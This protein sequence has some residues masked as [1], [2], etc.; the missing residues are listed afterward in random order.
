LRNPQKNTI[1][2]FILA[3]STF[4]GA[5]SRGIAHVYPK[6]PLSSQSLEYAASQIL[7]F[8][9]FGM[10]ITGH[11]VCG[12]QRD[13][14]QA[15]TREL[16]V[17]SYQLALVTP[18]AVYNSDSK[19]LVPYPDDKETATYVASNLKA[20][21]SLLT[22]QRTELY[23]ISKM[24]GALNRPVFAEFPDSTF[25]S[26]DDVDT[27]MY[28]DAIKVDFVFQSGTTTKTVN[29]P[30][31]SYWFNLFDFTL[32][33]PRQGDHQVELPAPLSTPIALQ[34]A[35]TIVPTQDPLKDG[36]RGTDG[37]TQIPLT[38]SALLD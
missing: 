28:G 23:K 34:K 15:E 31:N 12:Y 36:R 24:G 2:S 22:Y 16:C 3:D 8:N 4:A 33:Y 29:L 18:L 14:T 17:R 20:R 6:L 30:E 9:M 7:N 26:P 27:M 37:L 21:L 1:G 11:N 38:I 32:V 10:P 19:N 5:G 35:G 13:D 25:F